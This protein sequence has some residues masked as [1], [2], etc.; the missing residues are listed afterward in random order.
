MI[1][2]KFFVWFLIFS[3]I[4]WIYESIYCTVK[5]HKWENRGFLFGPVCPIY[6]IGGIGCSFLFSGMFLKDMSNLEIFIYSCLG[7]MV[8]EYSTSWILEKVFHAVWWDYSETPLNLNG[9]ICLPATLGFGFGGLMVIHYIFPFVDKMTRN[10]GEIPMT[11][12][13]IVG[14]GIISADIA[15]TISAITGLTQNVQTIEENVNL[16][17]EALYSTIED[18]IKGTKNKVFK[19]TDAFSSTMKEL[20]QT[21]KEI[22]QVVKDLP[23]TVKELPSTMKDISGNMYSNFSEKTT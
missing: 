20:P 16:Q 1:I 17:M 23:Q 22:P 7:S 14:S 8:L 9:R 19:T 6:G 2:A 18:S 5:S 3:I 4:G 21:V 13:A 11:L 15:V 12:M 10:V